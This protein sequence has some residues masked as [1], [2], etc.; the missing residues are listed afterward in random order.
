MNRARHFTLIEILV[1][2]AIIAILAALLLPA[3]NKARESARSAECRNRIRTLGIIWQNYSDDSNEFL[4]PVLDINS[5]TSLE[6]LLKCGYFPDLPVISGTYEAAMKLYMPLKNK[7]EQR[8]MCPTATSNW[9][10]YQ[11][12]GYTVYGDRPLPISYAYNLYFAPQHTAAPVDMTY[13]YNI[14]KLSQI[15]QAS[16]TPVWG[17]TWKF[18]I[19]K[20]PDQKFAYWWF[21]SRHA[22]WAESQDYHAHSNGNI[23]VF[24]DLHLGL[25]KSSAELKSYPWYVE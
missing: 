3:L 9:P 7:F 15:K 19:A 23:F 24:A 17:E 25:M 8:F 18:H 20:K 16:I 5:T 2:I 1:V 4:L 21:S 6:Y 22:A 14:W 12:N 10:F 11:I 13:K